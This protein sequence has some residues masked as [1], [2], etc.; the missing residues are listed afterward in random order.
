M[1]GDGAGVKREDLLHLFTAEALISKRDT[2][3]LAEQ[4]EETEPLMDLLR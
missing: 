2:E 1:E 4:R 3:N